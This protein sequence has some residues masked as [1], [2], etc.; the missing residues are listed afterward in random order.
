MCGKRWVEEQYPTSLTHLDL[1][2]V[3]DC[4]RKG[5]S[6]VEGR[7]IYSKKFTSVHTGRRASCLL[8]AKGE[9]RKSN[10]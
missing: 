1:R 2:T 4:H 10:I 5:M 7:V 3:P 6:V 9:L 8:P